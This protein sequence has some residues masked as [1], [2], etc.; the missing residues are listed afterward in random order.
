[1]SIRNFFALLADPTKTDLNPAAFFISAVVFSIIHR[2]SRIFP[3][4]CT[5]QSLLNFS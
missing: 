1:M 2:R 3:Q 4:I 5:L